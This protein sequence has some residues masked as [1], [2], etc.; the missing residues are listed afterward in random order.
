MS[1]LSLHKW[2]IPRRHALRGLGACVTLPFLD[3]MRSMRAFA[4]LTP[5]QPR[6]CAF[7]YLPNGVNTI[8]FQI[9]EEGPGY[10]MSKALMPLEKHRASIT[11]ISGLHHPN[12]LGFHH[13]CQRIWLTGGKL[14]PAD[15]NSVSLDQLD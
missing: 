6:R 3:C 1:S 9:E 11:P 7:T 13:S 2:S 12:G 5:E 14:G 4:E 15:R 10:V 8:D